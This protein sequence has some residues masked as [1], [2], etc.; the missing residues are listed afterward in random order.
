[1]LWRCTRTMN[2]YCCDSRK[3]SKTSHG[4]CSRP[5]SATT[6]SRGPRALCDKVVNGFW[7]P[8][9]AKTPTSLLFMLFTWGRCPQRRIAKAECL[10]HLFLHSTVTHLPQT[11]VIF[12]ILPLLH[13][14]CGTCTRSALL[15]TPSF[16]SHLLQVLWCQLNPALKAVLLPTVTPTGAL[17][18]QNHPLYIW[19]TAEP[20]VRSPS[21]TWACEV[22]KPSALWQLHAQG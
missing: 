8:E 13:H 15:F 5:K 18:S 19:K 3:I 11:V 6:L 14:S 22:A 7:R 20:G 4:S 10:L 16:D 12:P 17:Q 9:S 21:N 1:M 2:T